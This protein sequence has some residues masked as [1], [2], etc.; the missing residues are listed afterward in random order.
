MDMVQ[1]VDLV[2]T[3]NKGALTAVDHVDF[4]VKKGELFGLIGPDGAGKTSIFRILTTLLMPT[5]GAATVAGLDVVKEYKQIRKLVGY[6][7]GKFSLYQDLTIEENLNFFAS[8]FG[9]TVEE[10]YDL[11]KDIYVQIEPFKDRRAGKLSGGMKQKLALC[12][13]LIHKPEVLFLDEPTT[14]VDVVSRKEFWEMLARLKDQ[15]ITIL[16]STPYMDEA[17]LCERIA[18]IQNG[19]ILSVETPEEI[20][21]QYPDPLYAIKANNMGKLLVDLRNNPNIKT[22]NAFGEYHH[23]SFKEDQGHAKE[24]LLKSLENQNHQGLIIDDI[25]PNIEDCFINLMN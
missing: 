1:V 18:L 23:I 7:P 11:I 2:K 8:V 5:E 17:T 22:C 21:K 14:G 24:M 19:Q 20:I 12:C 13:A 16:V 10:N 9:T 25:Q 6:M 15:G 4:S 3:Y